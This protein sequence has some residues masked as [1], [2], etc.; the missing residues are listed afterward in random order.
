MTSPPFP[1]TPLTQL[2]V[3]VSQRV[4]MSAHPLLGPKFPYYLYLCITSAWFDAHKLDLMDSLCIHRIA[5]LSR[6]FTRAVFG[7]KY[8]HL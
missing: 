4:C 2:Y 1:I 5:P 6:T 8:T 7:N 3:F